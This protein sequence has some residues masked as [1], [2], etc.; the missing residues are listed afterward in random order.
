MGK[1]S[2]PYQDVPNHAE[3]ALIISLANNVA[4]QYERMGN[5][6]SAHF[7]PTVP[8]RPVDRA[9][10]LSFKATVSF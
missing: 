6:L 10:S 3:N 1:L 8:F 2:K 9:G 5:M 7:G 4:L